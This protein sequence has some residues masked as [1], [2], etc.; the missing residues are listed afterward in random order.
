MK[1]G[2]YATDV[3]AKI[4]DTIRE[5][6]KVKRVPVVIGF[7]QYDATWVNKYFTIVVF[8]KNFEIIENMGKGDRVK[9]SGRVTVS[10]WTN[11]E[12]ETKEQWSIL[13][14]EISLVDTTF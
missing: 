2:F 12:G 3:Y 5:S 4:T 7:K 11:K 6:G 10:N 1:Y 9:V 14:D 13:A 8:E